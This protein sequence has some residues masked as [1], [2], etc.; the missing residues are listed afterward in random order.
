VECAK[1]PASVELGGTSQVYSG[2]ARVVTATTVPAGQTVDIT[3]DGSADAPTNAGT[4]A[5]SGVVNEVN[6]QG[7]ATGTLTV[8]KADQAIIFPDPGRQEVTNK[9]VLNATAGTAM[10]VS[11]SVVSGPAVISNAVDLSFLSAGR[12]TLLATQGG[13]GNWT[14]APDVTNT[15]DVIGVITNVTPA[16]GTVY[17]GTQVTIEGLWLGDGS[18]ITGVTLCGIAATIVTQGIHSVT[19]TTGVSPVV[20]NA[21]VVVRSAGFGAAALTNGFTYQPVP[22]PPVALSAVD[23]TAGGFTAR[24]TSSEGATNYLIDVSAT[25]TFTSFAGIYNNWNAGDVTACLVTGLDDGT[26]YYYRVRAA[27]SYGAST[28]SNTV[29][30]PVSD[31]TPY[32]QYERTNGVASAGSSDVIDMTKLFHGTGKSYSVVANSN[33]GL[34]TPSFAGTDLVL[35]YAAGGSGTASITVRVTDPSGFWVETTVTVAVASAP[36]LEAGPIALNRQNGLFEQSVTVSNTSPLTA[37]AVTL[38]VRNLSAGATLNNATGVDEHGN[39]EIQWAG[40]FA[41][42]SSMVFTLQ[43]YT[44]NRS[45]APT[46]AVEVSLSLED[47]ATLIRGSKFSINGKPVTVGTTQSFLIEFTAVPGRTYHIQYNETLDGKTW[48]TAQPPVVAPA[49]RIQWIDSGPPGTESAP[50]SVPSRFYQVIEAVRER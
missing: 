16:T 10:T 27:N 38:T 20:T 8:A 5:V 17:G 11:F 7:G 12:V 22:P 36:T 49:N 18:D 39:A 48:K 33:P 14:A 9:V 3:Y 45:V 19:V 47:P 35:D 28:D 15:F 23:V 42:N 26:T 24:W 50:G 31:N 2:A 13:D 44:K 29:E 4:Y 25:N 1:A 32:I 34:V 21:D 46:S 37:R 6:Y 43:Y 40:A 41:P 30:V